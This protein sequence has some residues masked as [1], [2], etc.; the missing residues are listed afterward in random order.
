MADCTSIY[1]DN[2]IFEKNITFTI[3]KI[4]K[5]LDCKYYQDKEYIIN[6]HDYDR[7]YIKVNVDCRYSIDEH[8][9]KNNEIELSIGDQELLLSKNTICIH[10]YTQFDFL[11]E[12]HHVMSFLHGE[13]DPVYE[14]FIK[15][16]INDIKYFSKLFESTQLIIFNGEADG[17]PEL[18][19]YEGAK[20]DDILMN[21]KYKIINSFPI[22]KSGIQY[23]DLNGDIEKENE[24][25]GNNYVYYEKWNNNDKLNPYIWENKFVRWERNN[26]RIA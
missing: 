19:L 12:W 26:R 14:E 4:C 16:K 18:L 22:K 11:S 15:Y 1:V 7:H 9:E 25:S 10:Q 23:E 17:S 24:Y 8:F 13:Y 5:I 6:R 2:N 3:N 21:N 20:I